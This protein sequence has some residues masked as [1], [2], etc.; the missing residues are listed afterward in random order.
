V[1]SMVSAGPADESKQLL[2][3]VIAN[4]NPGMFI[5][6]P[7]IGADGVLTFK[8]KAAG[9][10]RLDIGLK[11]GGGTLNGGVNQ[12]PDTATITITVQ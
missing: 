1:M 2:T 7:K 5:T 12:S 8:A 11:D 10:A 6:Q 4:S 9:T 3:F